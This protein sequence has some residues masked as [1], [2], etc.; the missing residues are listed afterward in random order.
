MKII[1]LVILAFLCLTYAG[2][3]NIETSSGTT[4]YN[5]ENIQT[6][7]FEKNTTETMKIHK[8]DGAIENI[9]VSSNVN[10]TFNDVTGNEII[11]ILN[12][13]NETDVYNLSDIVIITFTSDSAIGDKEKKLKEIPISLLKN[14]P[15]PFNPSTN[16]S[17]NINNSGFVKVG[18]YNKNGKLVRNLM[19][20]QVSSGTYNL[21]WD[22]KNSSSKSVSSGFYFTKVIFWISS[23]L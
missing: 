9:E 6:I 7:T 13:N 8:K 11:K 18:V 4:T 22:G 16:I 12:K 19:T 20:K 2:T 23:K 3:I 5:F 17:F 14:Y 21:N 15:N 1:F 10:I